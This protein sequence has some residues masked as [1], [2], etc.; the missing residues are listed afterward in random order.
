[1]VTWAGA[2]RLPLQMER[3][4]V[5]IPSP[6]LL[7]VAQRQSTFPV[8]A[9]R[10]CHPLSRPHSPQPSRRKPFASLITRSV[11]SIRRMGRSRSVITT[12]TESGRRRHARP[13]NCIEVGV[14]RRWSVTTANEPLRVR[15]PSPGS[16]GEA[17]VQRTIP[18]GN[19]TPTPSS[20]PKHAAGGPDSVGYL[21]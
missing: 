20:C 2:V 19:N 9:T 17:L 5:R 18:V 14:G 15:V 16:H 12:H 8:G 6:G 4:R 10:P 13:D 3:L 1:M 7:G 21:H 11:T